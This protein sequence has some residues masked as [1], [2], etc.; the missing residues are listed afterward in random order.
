LKL[1]E[2]YSK[3]NFYDKVKYLSTDT[4]FIINKSSSLKNVAKNPYMKNKNCIKL[5]CLVDKEGVPLDLFVRTGNLNDSPML[6]EHF[7]TL[8]ID[9]KAK[10][11]KNNNRYKPYFFALFLSLRLFLLLIFFTW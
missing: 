8:K 9:T 7:E 3:S 6:R 1:Y 4:T 11:L 10:H 5:S 2:E